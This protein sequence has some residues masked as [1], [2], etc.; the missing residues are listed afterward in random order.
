MAYTQISVT[1]EAKEI[2]N[3]RKRIAEAKAHNDISWDDFLLKA[4]GG[5]SG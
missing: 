2:L 4:T 3:Q 1:A 5:T